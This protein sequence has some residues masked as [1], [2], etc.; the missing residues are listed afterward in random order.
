[1]EGYSRN[2]RENGED[3]GDVELTTVK[4]AIQKHR[5]RKPADFYNLPKN[6]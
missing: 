2:E 5:I 6:D 1:M 4:I 3:E